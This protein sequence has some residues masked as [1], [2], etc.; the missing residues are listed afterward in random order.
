MDGDRKQFQLDDGELLLVVRMPKELVCNTNDQS[1]FT[2]EIKDG[3]S[4]KGEPKDSWLSE[5]DRLYGVL[6]AMSLL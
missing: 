3:E 1:E 2:F 6:F 4:K 5:A